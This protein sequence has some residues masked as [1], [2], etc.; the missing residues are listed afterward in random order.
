MIMR[1]TRVLYVVAMALA[2]VGLALASLRY[3]VINDGRVPPL[4]SLIA[5]SF[6][7][8]LGVMAAAGRGMPG[9]LSMNARMAGF[10][11]G[12]LLYLGVRLA[13]V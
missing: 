13:M 2:G 5:I 4:M 8:E 11:A 10:F 3:P 9:A 12:A 7:F 1:D 6:V